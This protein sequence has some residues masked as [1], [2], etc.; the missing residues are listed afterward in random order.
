M[1]RILTILLLALA[2]FTN[3]ASA[4]VT[5]YTNQ[6]TFLAA[7]NAGFYTENFQSLSITGTTLG[8]LNFSSGGFTYAANTT[9][10]NLFFGA[11]TPA[12]H[13]L[14]TNTATDT[15]TITFSSGNVT[16]VGGFFF[17]SDIAGAATA[18][19][20][21]VGTNQTALQ[22]LLATTPTTFLGFT[23]PTPFTSLTLSAIQATTVWPT[24]NDFIVG[25]VAAI[26]EPTTWA[27]MGIAGICV[28]VGGIYQRR[29][30]AKNSL[31]KLR[32]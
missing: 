6:A 30:L 27:L 8:P 14:S 4:Q 24:A 2:V 17:T 20:V 18:G 10:G 5:T 3:Q 19:G 31:K 16:A 11:G 28:G 13:W 9:T 1:F 26:P 15:V 25:T 21:T 12:D 22:N 7:L 29:K 32:R 23:S